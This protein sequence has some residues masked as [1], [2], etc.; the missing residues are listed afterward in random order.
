MVRL[1]PEAVV[2]TV[3]VGAPVVVVVPTGSVAGVGLVVLVGVDEQA[4]ARRTI[5][6]LSEIRRRITAIQPDIGIYVPNEALR[7]G[8]CGE[9][10]L[11]VCRPA[12]QS[13][14]GRPTGVAWILR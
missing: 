10:T 9:E 2:T 14:T 6:R 1:I 5:V 12:K 7:A 8:L 13:A 3:V 4:A 11:N